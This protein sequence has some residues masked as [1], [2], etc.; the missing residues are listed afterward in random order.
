MIGI[1]IPVAL[2]LKLYLL[3]VLLTDI[4]ICSL[5]CLVEYG[6]IISSALY[7]PITQCHA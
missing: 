2:D 5:V 7:R 1:L 6:I 3:I 4:W